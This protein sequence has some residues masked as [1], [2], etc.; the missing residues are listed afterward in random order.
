MENLGYIIVSYL[1]IL[2]V[3]RDYFGVKVRILLQKSLNMENLRYIIVSCLYIAIL[4]EA[5]NFS[6]VSCWMACKVIIHI[7]CII[8]NICL[9]GNILNLFVHLYYLSP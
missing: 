3:E 8:L 7:T 6:N 5:A 1:Y 9:L 2:T 4:Y